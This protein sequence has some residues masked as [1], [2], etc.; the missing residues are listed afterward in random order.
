MLWFVLL[1]SIGL[2]SAGAGGEVR[3]AQ[4]LGVG[5]LPVFA[6]AMERA[7]GAEA[8]PF[9]S[10]LDVAEL[11]PRAGDALTWIAGGP[12]RWSVL[13]LGEDGY[14]VAGGSGRNVAWL[15]AYVSVDPRV[16]LTIEVAGAGDLRLFVDGV[17][18]AHAGSPDGD[19]ARV[20]H[21][22]TMD[23]GMHR[24]LLRCERDG[25]ATPVSLVVRAA[26]PGQIRAGIDPRHP[27]TDYRELRGLASVSGLALSPDGA[28]LA[29]SRRD[30]SPAG[31]ARTRLEIV[32]TADGQVIGEPGGASARAVQWDPAG[33]RLLYREGNTLLVWHRGDGH[34]EAVLVDEPGLG[35]VDWSRDGRLLVFSS[36]R[37]AKAAASGNQ[38]RVDLREKLSDWPTAP[39]LHV[40]AL[41]SSARRRLIAPGD[42]LQDAFEILSDNRTLVYLRNLPLARRPWFYSEVRTLD[43]YTGD[44]RLVQRL[45]MGFENRPGMAGLAASPDGQR[46]AFVG[47]PSELGDEIEVE[48]N[49]FDP[50]LYI[51]DL[52]DGHW[53]NAT[54]RLAAS[55]SGE[56]SWSGDSNRV[57]FVG[58]AGSRQELF[59][60]ILPLT[61]EAVMYR[62]VGAGGE[63]IHDLSLD[64]R[65]HFA[66]ITS[67]V[68]RLPALRLGSVAGGAER[69]AFLEP[70][71]ELLSRLLLSPASD[72]SFTLD[73]G[74]PIEGW[75]LR[76][77]GPF[78][79]AAGEKLPLIVYYYGG[80]TPTQRGFNELHQF[81]VGN[82][83]ALL[84]IN[85]RGAN[86]YGRGFA[87]GHVADWGDK[88]GADI[89]AGVERALQRNPDLDGAHV[90]CYGGSYGG[91][92]TMHL[93]ARSDRF[94]AAVSMYGISDLAS[95]FGEGI[96]GYTYG[97]Q[98]MARR[99]PWSDP[100]WFVDHSPLYQAD[101]IHTPLLLLH[102]EA[103]TNVPI[104]E[105]E[106]MFTALR[107]LGRNVEM[108]RF[109][110]EDHG[111]RGTF[112]NRVAHRTM[113]LEWFDRFLRDQPEAWTARWK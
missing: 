14:S 62:S 69:E 87:D 54:A 49:A 97:D 7:P 60:A 18:V 41:G 32:R 104:G 109:P 47:P 112:D 3:P 20:A 98:A 56:L 67:D 46:I 71:R 29:M 19:A 43:L 95:Y 37:G 39:H 93:I 48:P 23:R 91:F 83:Y 108:V 103:D 45:T 16:E 105:A 10:E 61:G 24:L 38:R 6:P 74:T 13:E 42:W 51:L 77:R 12:A 58:N 86:A 89:L 28:L 25:V 75:L 78:A 65:G 15:A 31:A 52:A 22:T 80:A 96:W 107:L 1:G 64:D 76:P 50:D 33:D 59:A 92:M 85:P 90:G 63:L 30:P 66:A 55:V 110:G 82:D 73:D 70:N 27:L 106:Q 84:V 11:W 36:T 72:A 9:T 94:A 57:Y 8:V 53:F 101:R 17:D 44:D 26:D 68:D 100:Q 111:L 5:P 102:G 79:L 35:E 81:L 113:L 2:V 21:T 34:S 40:L 88:A 4:V 99:Y